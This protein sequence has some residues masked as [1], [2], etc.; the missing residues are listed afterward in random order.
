MTDAHAGPPRAGP[1]AGRRDHHRTARSGIGKRRGN[2]PCRTD[3][4]SSGVPCRRSVNRRPPH[5]R[6]PRRR[7]PDGRHLARGLRARRHLGAPD[8]SAQWHHFLP[9]RRL[10]IEQKTCRPS[11]CRAIAQ[12]ASN[13]RHDSDPV[14]RAGLLRES[15]GPGQRGHGCRKSSIRR[16]RNRLDR[17]GYVHR[18][19]SIRRWAGAR[20]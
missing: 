20:D 13:W 17:G 7:L 11:D 2:D 14:I 4:G 1:H 3:A 6:V 10:H 8:D 18:G 5:L 9:P 12:F 15:V 19:R 16:A